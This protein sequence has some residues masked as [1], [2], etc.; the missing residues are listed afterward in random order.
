MYAEAEADPEQRLEADGT[1]LVR[2]MPW[3]RHTFMVNA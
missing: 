2:P 3:R 1:T